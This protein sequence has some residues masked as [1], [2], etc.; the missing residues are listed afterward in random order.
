MLPGFRTSSPEIPP[1]LPPPPTREDPAIREARDIQSQ[2]ERRRKGRR[3]TILT[4]A[5]GIED[6]LGL[7]QAPRAGARLLGE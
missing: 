4:S 6:D 5:R 1:P 2:L 3:G 7:T